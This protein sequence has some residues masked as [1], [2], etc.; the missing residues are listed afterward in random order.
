VIYACDDATGAFRLRLH[1]SA[2]LN[3]L[4]AQARLAKPIFEF[5]VSRVRTLGPQA[6]STSSVPGP[7]RY[8]RGAQKLA[9]SY[10]NVRDLKDIV[11]GTLVYESLPEL[12][13]A[14]DTVVDVAR[15]TSN[16]AVVKIK[17]R[18]GDVYLPGRSPQQT[19]EH[20]DRPPAG[21][22]DVNVT[23]RVKG[24][25]CELQLNLGAFLDLKNG[26]G[27]RFYEEFRNIFMR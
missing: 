9:S 2:A 17:N 16:V 13:D 1:G 7:K 4:I 25:L 6:L 14:L 22:C 12:A 10:F 27:H 21:Y 26:A 20:P 11:R 3:H 5:F 19:D 8:K 18:F 15:T 24:H 23:L